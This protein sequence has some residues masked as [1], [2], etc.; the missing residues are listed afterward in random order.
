M[1]SMTLRQLIKE[2]RTATRGKRDVWSV[3]VMSMNGV[4]SMPY[5]GERTACGSKAHQGNRTEGQVRPGRIYRG[6]RRTR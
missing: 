2:T 4:A 1:V 3:T 6:S 5:Y